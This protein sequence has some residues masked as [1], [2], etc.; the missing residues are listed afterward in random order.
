MTLKRMVQLLRQY[1]EMEGYGETPVTIELW[2]D[3]NQK[4]Y[5][6]ESLRV[7]PP[8]KDGKAVAIK[9]IAGSIL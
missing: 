3:E 5:E 4:T 1:S 8:G 2:G 6:I 7:D 9:I